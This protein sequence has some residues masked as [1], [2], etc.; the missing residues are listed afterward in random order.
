LGCIAAAD[1]DGGPSPPRIFVHRPALDVEHH[2]V[3]RCWRVECTRGD[4]HGNPGDEVHAPPAP[5]G[6]VLGTPAAG[7]VARHDQIRTDEPAPRSRQPPEHPDDDPER[8][9][10]DDP[11][12]AGGETEV[13]GI[14]LENPHSSAGELLAQGSRPTGVEFKGHDAGPGGRESSDEHAIARTDVEHQVTVADVGGRDEAIGPRSIEP[15][16]PPAPLP[17]GAH[18][19]SP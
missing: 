7:D 13:G 6:R 15:V 19:T 11:E 14:D 17:R 18:G 9:I 16:P 12:A 4:A 8:W 10:R 5:A 1:G 3:A 2:R